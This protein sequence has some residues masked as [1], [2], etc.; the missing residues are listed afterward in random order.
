M[1]KPAPAELMTLTAASARLQLSYGRVRDLGLK[2][3]LDLHQVDG[4]VF[5]TVVSVEAYGTPLQ[6]A[7]R[8]FATALGRFLGFVTAKLPAEQEQ[9]VMESFGSG[10]VWFELKAKYPT[11][12]WPGYEVQVHMVTADGTRTEAV[13]LSPKTLAK[14]SK[15][16]ASR[17]EAAPAN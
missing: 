6:R 11:S 17:A 1:A 9:L 16:V 8:E 7:G 10:R 4:R 12:E 3:E 14:F 5:V 13:D 15:V 2:G